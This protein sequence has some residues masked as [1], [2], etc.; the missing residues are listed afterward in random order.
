MPKEVEVWKQKNSLAGFGHGGLDSCMMRLFEETLLNGRTRAPCDLKE[1]LRI[2]L[3]GI[4]AC[5]SARNGG[6]PEKIYY[7][8]DSKWPE[9]L[10]NHGMEYDFPN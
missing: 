9:F 1:G 7:P 10:S 6:M 4:F 5:Q 8:W 3:P 2:T